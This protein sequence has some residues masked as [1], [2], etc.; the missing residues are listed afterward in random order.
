MRAD[1]GFEIDD[2]GRAKLVVTRGVTY[3]GQNSSVA[4]L[5]AA[6]SL[7]FPSFAAL[8][9]W[10]RLVLPNAFNSGT[11]KSE[12]TDMEVVRKHLRKDQEALYLEEPELSA[13][14]KRQVLGQ[15]AAIDALAACVVRHCARKRPSRPLVTFSIGPSGVGKT[16]ASQALAQA[17][18]KT[19]QNSGFQFLR[20]DMN[21]YQEA[22]RVSQLLGAPQGYVGHG[23]GSELVNMLSANP[24]TVVL[25]DEIEKAHPAILKTLMNAMDAGRLSSPSRH[26]RQID[27][28]SSIFMFTSNLD[29]TGTLD[30]IESRNA[31]ANRPVE[32]EICRRRLSAAGVPAEIVGRINRFLIF[33]PLSVETKAEIVSLAIAE[34]ADEYG[35][36]VQKV[37]PTA[38]LEIMNE[39]RSQ[40]FGVRPERFLI[41]AMLGGVLAKAARRQDRVPMAIVGPPFDCQP[42]SGRDSS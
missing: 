14:L 19:D 11:P 6:G 17:L 9:D 32:D 8:R 2:R 38:V 24:R 39:S 37:A 15:D 18:H 23:E 13:T 5:F 31:Q 27:C 42:L 3:C 7:D 28:R 33:G 35:I 1:I 41:D 10:C 20:L 34:V 36:D 21:E 16:R 12:I 26:A 29:A 25:F 40:S 4:Q 30:E 22:F